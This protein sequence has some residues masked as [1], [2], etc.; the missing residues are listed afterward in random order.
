MRTVDTGYCR[1]Q[2][3]EILKSSLP[4]LQAERATNTGPS[5]RKKQ[6]ALALRVVVYLSNDTWKRSDLVLTHCLV[7]VYISA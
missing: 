7:S 1:V 2:V 6:G 3:E 5:C 4:D